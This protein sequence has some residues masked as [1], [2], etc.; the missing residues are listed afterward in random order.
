M[1]GKILSSRVLGAL[2]FA[3]A[4]AT[5]ACT[6][7][8]DYVWDDPYLIDRARSALASGDI[9]KLFTSSFYVKTLSSAR[10]YRPVM[11]ATLL[12][13]ISLTGGVPWFSHLVNVLIHALNSL[14]VYLLLR[15]ILRHG[16]GALAGALLFAVHPVHAEA[17]TGVSNRMDL[18]ALTLLL[19]LAIWW[20]HPGPE[21]APDGP[22][23][24]LSVMASFS[25]AC[26]TKETAFMLP[27]VLLG[28][29]IHRRRPPD[30]NTVVK[31][32][33]VFSVSFAVFLLRWIVFAR[34]MAVS[35]GGTIKAGALLPAVPLSRILM[36]LLVNTRLA[37]LPFPSRSQ[38]AGS[39]LSFEWTTILASL[40]FAVLVVWA[41]R[42]CPRPAA[43]GL[44]W[45]LFFTLPVLGF[46][47]LGQV[48]AAERY[49]YIPSVGLVMIVGGLVATLPAP[50][51]DRKLIK[52]LAVA[53]FVVLGI[54]AAFHTRAMKN[55]I[56]LF[57]KV[58]ATNPGFATVHLNLGAALAREGRIEEALQSYEAAEA[59]VPGWSDVAFNRGNLL[60][61]IGRY[62]EA[63]EDYRLVLKNH[64]ED[65]EAEL[66]LGNA[67]LAL[68]RTGDAAGSFRRAAVLNASSGKP[69]VALGALAHRQGEFEQAVHF[70]EK[71]A[72]R[73]PGLSEAYEGMGDAYRALGRL[74][75]AEKALLKAL[76]VSPGNARAALK[77]GWFL[78][79]SG[80]PVQAVPAF[81]AALAAEPALSQA[82]IGLIRSL[83]L[84]GEKSRSD[85]LIR[86]LELED[87]ALAARVRES[88][89]KEPSGMESR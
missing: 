77:M 19:P 29:E 18:L 65:W 85:D 71:A 25:M 4:L 74:D 38:W 22:A 39:D 21:E 50:V 70:F 27:I 76:E 40:F 44:I 41:F 49:A 34:E 28:W 79:G 2:V 80:R 69:L 26:L 51:L 15:R 88:R 75:R 20:S 42:R 62:E 7:G 11:L 60:Y 64:P 10:Y 55:E 35:A 54:G 13:E 78:L 87:A 82:W 63:V 86:D 45:W 73:E 3:A 61:R 57:R 8:Y 6:I 17:V 12:G 81:R 9:S 37:V 59:V 89:L 83:D 30:R 46:V 16:K 1:P 47:N 33:Y 72:G 52:N 58:A 5:Y 24:R 14:L 66:N 36:D 56:T 31:L 84:T 68:G 23:L 53:A 43:L 48:V 32:L 67:Y